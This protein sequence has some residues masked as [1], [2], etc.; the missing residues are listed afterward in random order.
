MKQLAL[1]LIRGSGRFCRCSAISVFNA[2]FSSCNLP[3]FLPTS[4]ENRLCF[5]LSY[6]SSKI[7]YLLFYFFSLLLRP[8]PVFSHV[9]LFCPNSVDSPASV[10]PRG[11][12]TWCTQANR[13]TGALW[14]LILYSRNKRDSMQCWWE[15]PH[16][17]LHSTFLHAGRY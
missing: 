6:L 2:C 3:L 7:Q 17:L 9:S 16:T 15:P 1:V 11:I 5:F 14:S 13:L 8:F 10:H 4:I 12:D